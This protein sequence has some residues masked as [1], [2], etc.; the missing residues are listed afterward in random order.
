VAERRTA[1]Q[2]GRA[3]ERAR[4]IER[5]HS[6]WQQALATDPSPVAKVAQA[7]AGVLDETTI[8]VDDSTCA[9]DT[10]IEQLPVRAPGSYYRPMGSSMGWGASAAF[11]AKLAAPDSTIISLNAEGNLLSGAPEAALWGAARHGAPFLTVVYDNAQYGA[12]RLQ[13]QDEYPDGALLRSGTALDIDRPPDL[14]ALAGSC[15]AYG[16]R[17]EDLRELGR[18]LDRGLDAVRGGQCALVDVVVPGP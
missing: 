9:I 11:G 5:A 10:N 6:E 12:I 4:A 14:V 15:D 2:G 16:E 18:A 1:A 7:V 13:V 8:V 17:V 3:Q